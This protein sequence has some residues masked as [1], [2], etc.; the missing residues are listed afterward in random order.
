MPKKLPLFR[1]R[2]FSIL[3]G[4]DDLVVVHG[5]RFSGK[6]TL[7]RTWLMT[8][9]I[10]AA[11][12]VFVEFPPGGITSDQYWGRVLSCVCACAGIT[13]I[14]HGRNN[15][16]TLCSAL[17][18]QHVPI[19]LMLDGLDAVESAEDRVGELLECGAQLRII[20]TTRIGGRWHRCIRGRPDRTMISSDALAF[21]VEETEA[22]L[23]ASAVPRSLRVVDR[24]TRRTGGLPALI[25]AVCEALKAEGVQ[26]SNDP[27][28]LDALID[29]TV[30]TLVLH[31][32]A[33]DPVLDPLFRAT[34][35]SSDGAT[36]IVSSAGASPQVTDPIGFADTLES[37]G[38]VESEPGTDEPTRR[39]PV[40]VEESLLRSADTECPDELQAA[41][42]TLV[43]YSLDR[44]DAHCPGRFLAPLGDASIDRIPAEVVDSNPVVAAIRR[45]HRKCA[46]PRDVPTAVEGSDMAADVSRE[47][48]ATIMRAMNLRVGGQFD[49]AAEVCD[50]LA[51]EPVPVFEKLDDTARYAHAFCYLHIGISY[52]LADRPGEATIMLRRAHSSGAGTS[53]ERDA[54]GTLALTHAVRGAT[55]DAQLWIDAEREHRSLLSETSGTQ[56]KTAG[57]VASVLV[58]LDRLVPDRA[59]G[60][61]VELGVPRENEELWAFVLYASG[62]YA[63]LAGLPADGLRYVESEMRTFSRAYGGISGQL[64]DAV[65]ADLNLALGHPDQAAQLVGRSTDPLTAA[66]RARICLLTG[67]FVGAETIVYSYGEDPQCPLRVSM[68][69]FVIG[70]AAACSL[71][72]RA[73]ARRHMSRAAARSRQTGMLRPFTGLA[74]SMTREVAALGVELP[75]DLAQIAAE[76]VTFRPSRP[77]VRL[78]PRERA[79][80]DGLL[81]GGSAGT[82]AETQFV[83]LNTV[84]TQLRSLYRKLGVHSRGD[85]IAAAR[86]VVLD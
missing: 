49:E 20:V 74:P 48:A 56:A 80:L 52:L 13:P 70:A 53:V 85:A 84:K 22:F 26:T 51:S 75:V 5:S 2:L 54:A 79:V 86:L 83:S 25:A 78:T 68:E 33:T 62:Q 19:V 24:I 27:E 29:S 39:Y 72:R 57:L 73:D 40:A 41:R 10:P 46:S 38:V 42:V 77:V 14:P 37:A 8:D 81:A 55:F 59:F 50:A 28:R 23:R 76:F 3:S 67:D 31:T 1:G 69:L 6:T 61:L 65:R 64:L 43:R 63:L 12:P 60:A 18:T 35:V 16:D 71:G 15:F 66:V 45:M 4:S 32:V 82:I 7:V 58:A 34:P 44:G 9:P 11:V 36:S 30:D 21:T 47:P 17:A